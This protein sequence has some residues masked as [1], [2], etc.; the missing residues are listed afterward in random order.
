MILNFGHT[1]AHGIEAASGYSRKVN[2]GEAV[3]I[4]MILATRL[5]FKKKIC[6]FETLKK[7]ESIYEINNLPK[8]LNKILSSKKLGKVVGFMQADK[9]NYDDKINLIL[10]KRIGKTT[11]PGAY[12]VSSSE[13][14]NIIKRI[15]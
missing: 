8:N 12:R 14:K 3:L 5:S 9:K 4:G 7:V 2:H 6:S 13:I 1:F 11:I 15:S 10:L